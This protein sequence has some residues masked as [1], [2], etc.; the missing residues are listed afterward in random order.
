MIHGFSFLLWQPWF[1]II[2]ALSRKLVYTY[3]YLDHVFHLPCTELEI[4]LPCNSRLFSLVCGANKRRCFTP[5]IRN[6]HR[7]VRVCNWETHASRKA[8]WIK[9]VLSLTQICMWDFCVY[10]AD[11]KPVGLCLS[12]LNISVVINAKMKENFTR[13]HTSSRWNISVEFY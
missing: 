6:H 10:S 3:F 8:R 13:L 12:E 4:V 2:C 11:V 1:R 7:S 9:S 5:G